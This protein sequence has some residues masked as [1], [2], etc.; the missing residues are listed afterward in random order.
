MD[1][2]RVSTGFMQK[3][4]ANAIT[5]AIKNKTGYTPDLK[6]NDP[7]RVVFDDEK[8]KLHVNLD[9]EL[10]KDELSILMASLL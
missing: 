9:A 8:V 6:F 10:T 7:I 2:M 5:K 3:I 4:I 1:E